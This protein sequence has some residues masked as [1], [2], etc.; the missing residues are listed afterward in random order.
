MKKCVVRSRTPAFKSVTPY[1]FLSLLFIFFS[2]SRGDAI[3]A[4]RLTQWS[5]GITVSIP[6]KSDT[7]D[8]RAYGAL[9]DS[10]ADDYAAFKAAID[11]LPVSGGVVKIPKGKYCIG[12]SITIDRGIVLF[13]AGSTQTKLYFKNSDTKPCIEIIKYQRGTWTNV[14]GGFTRGSHQVQVSDISSFTVGN[15]AEIQ[16]AN[17]SSVMYTDP[18]WIQS[19][20]ENSVGQFFIIEAISGNTLTLNRPLYLDY[21]AKLNPQIRKQGLVTFAGVEN[22]FITKT[23]STADGATISLKNV[24]YCWVKAVE[25]DHTKKAHIMCESVYACVFRDSYF[26][27]SY[28]YAG[29][30]HGYGISLGLHVTDCLIENTIFRH[31]RH[32]MLTQL[33]A[34]GNVFGYNYSIDNVQGVGETD[35]NQEWT[36]C[37]IS[38][39]GHFPNNNL[40]EGNLVQE[41]DIADYWGPCGEG[42]TVFRNKVVQEGI[43]LFDHSNDQNIAANV[44]PTQSYGITIGSEIAG[45][46]S[47]GNVINGV[48]QWDQSITDHTFPNSYYLTS[49]PAFLGSTQWPVFGPDVTGEYTLP[50]QQR[51]ETGNY[52]LAV[53]KNP[54]HTPS[55]TRKFRSSDRIYNIKGQKNSTAINHGFLNVNKTKQTSSGRYFIFNG[56]ENVNGITVIR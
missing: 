25:S 30:G 13:G 49:K 39:H 10:V 48:V 42:N 35:L 11:A 36:P 33:G 41:I 40:Y 22:L 38:M 37:D 50:A 29:D 47:H 12:Q 18:E 16:Q 14:T 34:S 52:I 24:A 6:A 27:H 21:N 15:F 8:V 46:L 5:P 32:A 44:L 4:G 31:L 3:P 7:V 54:L 28:D 56:Q 45:T 9:G 1:Y 55:H 19:W 53:K 26:H 17:D 43:D 51:Y 20:A 2:S 23:V